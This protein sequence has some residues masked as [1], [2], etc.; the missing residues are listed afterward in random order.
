ML[1]IAVIIVL[2][3][4]VLIVGGSLALTA[5]GII[6]GILSGLAVFLIK[7]AVVVAIGYLILVG[8]RAL[9]R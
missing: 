7:L 5:V 9:L 1:R 6:I 3:L 4:F 2:S 8:V